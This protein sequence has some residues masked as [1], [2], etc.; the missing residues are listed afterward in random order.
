MNTSCVLKG[1]F[2]FLIK[3]SYLSKKKKKVFYEKCS[4]FLKKKIVV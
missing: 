2:L 4:I 3:F 1:D